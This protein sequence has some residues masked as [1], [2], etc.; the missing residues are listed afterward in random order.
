MSTTPR[1]VHEHEFEPQY[2]L[3]ERLPASERL[4]WQG[5]PSW[6]LLARRAFHADKVA[7]YFALLLAWRFGATLSDGAGLVP[8]LR[9]TAWLLP[10]FASGLALLLLLAWL[11]ARSAVY[12]LTDRRVVMRIGIV[13]TVTYNL[14]LARIDRA[15]LRPFGQGDAGDIA[16][17]LEPA[18]R[19]AWLHLWPHVRPWRVSRPQPMLRSLPEARRVSALLAAAWSQANGVAATPAGPAEAPRVPSRQPAFASR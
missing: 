6:T 14:P 12:T 17:A 13:L 19:I 5:S 9:S 2:G 18:T 7:I 4:V 8:A 11:T 10:L 15:D 1:A 16:L 3:P